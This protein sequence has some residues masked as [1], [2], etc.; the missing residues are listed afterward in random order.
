MSSSFSV[1]IAA[2]WS[3]FAG[4]SGSLPAAQEPDGAD[5]VRLGAEGEDVAADVGVRAGDRLLD[6]LH[7]HAVLLQQPGVEQHLVLLDGPAV[8]GHVD[9]AG[10]LLQERG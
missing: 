10:H 1:S 4:S 8:A 3:T 9:D 7:R 5:V 2:A 6:L